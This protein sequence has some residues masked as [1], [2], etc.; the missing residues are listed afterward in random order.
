[1]G[2][3]RVDRARHRLVALI[4]GVGVRYASLSA[5]QTILW[6][7]PANTADSA[8][9]GHALF[10]GSEAAIPSTTASAAV[11]GA[12]RKV[13]GIGVRAD[14]CGADENREQEEESLH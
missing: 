1:M 8:D 5:A 4:E 3:V 13:P 10:E 6:I 9:S 7:T 11:M 12:P 2:H 14:P